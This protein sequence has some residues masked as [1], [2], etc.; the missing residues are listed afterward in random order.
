LNII[1]T[2]NRVSENRV[3]GPGWM[4]SD[5]YDIVAKASPNSTNSQLYE[6]AKNELAD[7]FKMVA[8]Q[9]RRKWAP[10]CRWTP[11]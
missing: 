9:G 5:Q 11:S 2:V 1:A 6:M 10:G 4:A 7:R 3:I 8:P